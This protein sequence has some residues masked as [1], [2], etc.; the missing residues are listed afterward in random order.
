[1]QPSRIVRYALP[2]ALVMFVAISANAQ[3]PDHVLS[4][5]SNQVPIG[6]Q[7]EVANNYDNTSVA[8]IAGWSWGNCI[9]DNTVIDIIAVAN[10]ETTLTVNGGQPP[11][12]V[13]VQILP[14]EGWDVG[15]FIDFFGMNSL[16]PGTGYE[17]H[18]ATYVGLAQGSSDVC[19]CDTLGTVPVVT[20]LFTP[21][22]MSIDPTTRCGTLDVVATYTRG[23][24]NVDGSYNISDAVAALDILFGG[25]PAECEAACDADADGNL[26]LADPIY[27]LCNLFVGGPNPPSNGTCMDQG[28]LDCEDN[29]DCPDPP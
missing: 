14:G 21:E 18:I 9:G 27:I 3:D 28:L 22:G 19:Y 13:C 17:L 4:I 8:L 29:G 11:S 7:A 26:N 10:G 16:P 20:H 5:G 25:V 15:V 1:M 12:F 6:N 2:V 24:C 23:D